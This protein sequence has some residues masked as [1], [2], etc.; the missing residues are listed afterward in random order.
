[1]VAE[2][3]AIG[4]AAIERAALPQQQ[5]VNARDVAR[6][7]KLMANEA[8]PT[9]D[10]YIGHDAQ[11]AS[12]RAAWVNDALQQATDFDNRFTQLQGDLKATL[13]LVESGDPV[14][15]MVAMANLNYATSVMTSQTT[16]AQGLATSVQHSS[17]TLLKNQG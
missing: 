9:S 14:E 3:Q 5:Y 15:I 10:I 13:A 12:G 17:Q 16:M 2:I 11:I 7:D 8:G 4:G 1:M 6:F